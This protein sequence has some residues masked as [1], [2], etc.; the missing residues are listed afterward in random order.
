LVSEPSLFEDRI[1]PFS[2]RRNESPKSTQ[3]SLIVPTY[4]ESQNISELINKIESFLSP[5]T[6]EIVIVDDNSPDGT[7]KIVQNLNR[8]Y[9]NI[10][11]C[12]RPG[13]LGLS[14]AVLYGFN[15]AD[16]DV[17]AVIDADLQHPPEVLL[18]MYRKLSEGYDLVVA[19]RY[20]DGGGIKGWTM[21]R[22]VVSRVA[23]YLVH[24]LFPN[25]KKVKD[26]MSG[27]FMI[28]RE[29]LTNTNL[30][31]IG[32]KILLEIMTKCRIKRVAEIPYTFTNRRNG[33]SNLSP[34]EI[35]NFIVHVYRIKLNS[36]M[37]N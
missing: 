10:R 14:S 12:K 25:S 24:T 28:K 4:N 36:R 31:P 21:R 37:Y 26:V 19:S 23:T 17:L 16:A 29:I 35:R 20:V 9:G 8:K 32:F 34:L 15:R 22:K 27:C 11:L 3:L 1:G 7:S 33:K 6:F 5:I 30:N 2:L 18:K 13:K